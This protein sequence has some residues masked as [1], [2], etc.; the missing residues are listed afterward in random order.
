MLPTD[1]ERILL[2]RIA[3]GDEN[4]FRVIFDKYKDKVYGFAFMFTRSVVQSEEIVQEIFLKLW[5]RKADLAALEKFQ[6]WLFMVT[7]NQS[8]TALRKIAYDYSYR[9]NLPA[10]PEADSMENQM[11]LKDY[12]QLVRS[13]VDELPP[14]QRKVYQLRREEGLTLDEIAQKLDIS[15]N[16]VKVHLG[17]ALS[18]IR[19]ALEG[20]LDLAVILI[21][22]YFFSN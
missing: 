16:T 19:K 15:P 8:F 14:Q 17:K 20:K 6:S 1:D 5:L 13:V 2:Q 11:V 10:D 22:T 12:Q 18:R 7:R 3:E 21:L 9:Q 4:A